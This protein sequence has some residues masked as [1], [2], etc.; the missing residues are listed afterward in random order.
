MQNDVPK[1]ESQIQ[2]KKLFVGG[3]LQTTTEG[4]QGNQL[5]RIRINRWA[6][7]LLWTVWNNW[8]FGYNDWQND[9]QIKR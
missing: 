3:L 8:G 9:R 2:T 5:G 7:S 4:K 6:S 1:D